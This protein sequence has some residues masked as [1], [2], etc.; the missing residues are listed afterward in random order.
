MGWSVNRPTGLTFHRP[1]LS[2]K[3]YTLLTPH[4][5]ACAYLIDMDG[6]VVHR[7]RFA[8]HPAGVRPPARERP[9]AHDRLRPGSPRPAARRADQAAAAVR[10]AR[11]PARRLPHHI[12]SRWTGTA[13]SCGSTRTGASTTTSSGSPTATRWCRSGSSSPRSCT[14]ASAAAI[15]VRGSACPACSGTTSSRSTVDGTEVRRIHVWELLDPVKDPINPSVAT[16]GVDPPQQRRRER[17]R[18]HRVLGAHQRPGRGDLRRDRRAHLQVH[19]G[20]R[21]A[22]R[23]LGRRRQH[24][25]VRQRRRHV[26]RDRDRPVDRRG[27]V[28]VPRDAAVPVLQRSHLGRVAPLVGNVLVCEGTSGRLFEVT[29]DH[30]GGVGVDQPVRELPQ[31]RADGVD[32]PRVP[33]RPRLPRARRARPR[34]G[35]P[36]RPQPPARL[37]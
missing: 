36:R 32:L 16:V 21:P 20:A 37:H 29:R 31:G 24:P 12:W 9:P 34:P 33:L 30:D 19:R 8:A 17:R 7:W 25:G 11:D 1:G 13:T 15:G 14:G 22:P 27:G 18:R 5:D 23:D 28:G 2:T 26:T 35:A 3:G 4:G 6:R 10:A